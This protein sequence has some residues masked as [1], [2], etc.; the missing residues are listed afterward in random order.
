MGA[1]EITLSNYNSLRINYNVNCSRGQSYQLKL[2]YK[3]EFELEQ[4][5]T[6]KKITAKMSAKNKI[7]QIKPCISIFLNYF[8]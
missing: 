6:M 2:K 4:K 3:Y 7:Q 1:K 8:F 5:T